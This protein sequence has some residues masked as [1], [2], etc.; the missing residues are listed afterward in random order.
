MIM[1]LSR[2]LNLAM[3]ILIT[4]MVVWARI[5]LGLEN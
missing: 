5:G 4:I 1:F 3:L 2:I